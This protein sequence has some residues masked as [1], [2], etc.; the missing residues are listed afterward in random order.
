MATYNYTVTVVNV[1]GYNK[2]HLNGSNSPALTLNT[3]DVVNF[4]LGDA[5]NATHPL[6]IGPT[7]NN[8]SDAYGSS[9]GVTYTVSG[10][11]YSTA[12]A[13]ETAY[14]SAKTSSATATASVSYTVPSG[15]SGTIYYFCAVHSG[16]GNSITLTDTSVDADVD[17]ASSNATGFKFD[18]GIPASGMNQ[19]ASTD[20]DVPFAGGISENYLIFGPIRQ[21]SGNSVVAGNLTVF[22]SL[23]IEGQLNI[24]GNVDIR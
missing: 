10:T 7:N 4:D 23:N 15:V 2:Y 9:E 24:T 12:S 3:A 14:I 11:T 13:Y 19:V 16:M 20:L 8:D 5:T 6:V 17:P 22:N 1:S 18:S 21:A